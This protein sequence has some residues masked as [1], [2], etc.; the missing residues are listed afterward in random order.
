MSTAL[1]VSVMALVVITLFSTVMQ[2]LLTQYVRV[3]GP[4]TV[5]M[6]LII[7]I[8]GNIF[9]AILTWIGTATVAIVWAVHAWNGY[10]TAFSALVTAVGIIIVFIIGVDAS[11]TLGKFKGEQE[12]NLSDTP[13]EAVTG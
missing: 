5:K 2:F 13:E 12:S 8:I 1:I 9:L 11:D 6:P 4:K 7:A 3:T 10:V